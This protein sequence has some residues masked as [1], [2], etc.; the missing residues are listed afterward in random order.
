MQEEENGGARIMKRAIPKAMGLI[1]A[2]TAGLLAVSSY[3]ASS[4]E[5]PAFQSGPGTVPSAA[6]SLAVSQAS[7]Y[8]CEDGDLSTVEQEGAAALGDLETLQPN[9]PGLGMAMSALGSKTVVYSAVIGGRC[10]YGDA[11]SATLGYVLF[12]SDGTV[13]FYRLWNV[14]NTPDLDAPF[15][16]GVNAVIA[17]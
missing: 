1:V 12:T 3:S 11:S 8:L 13:I 14:A 9:T 4:S 2:V 10:T 6:L 16:L 5:L 7:S 15:G 17:S